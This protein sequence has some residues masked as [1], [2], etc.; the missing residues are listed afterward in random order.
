MQDIKAIAAQEAEKYAKTEWSDTYN[1]LLPASVIEKGESYTA[2][3]YLDGFNKCLELLAGSEGAE[4]MFDALSEYADVLGNEL[5]LRKKDLKQLLAIH[6]AKMLG[7]RWI[8]TVDG[9]PERLPEH[10]NGDN[11]YDKNASITVYVT[12]YSD[13]VYNA[14]WDFSNNCWR[15]TLD[16]EILND[17]VAWITKP[18]SPNNQNQSRWQ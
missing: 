13:E 12:D 5:V 4:E 7:D 1:N 16:D 2:K 8:Y 6:T 18:Q 14:Y 10:L 3:N 15:H 11:V 9:M 17:V